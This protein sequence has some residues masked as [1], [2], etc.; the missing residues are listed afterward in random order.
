VH[1]KIERIAE[2]LLTKKNDLILPENKWARDST[3]LS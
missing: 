3:E 1:P 2:E